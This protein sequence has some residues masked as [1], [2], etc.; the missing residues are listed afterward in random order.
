MEVH[1][2]KH[3]VNG[4]R[5]SSLKSDIFYDCRIF[6]EVVAIQHVLAEQPQRS[7]ARRRVSLLPLPRLGVVL[8][9]PLD[10]EGNVAMLLYGQDIRDPWLGFLQAPGLL[11][12]GVPA[13]PPHALD[14]RP[15]GQQVLGRFRRRRARSTARGAK[16]IDDLVDWYCA[17]DDLILPG[18]TTAPR[19]R[20]SRRRR[21][22][23]GGATPKPTTSWPTR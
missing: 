2:I 9:A 7:N 14:D 10:F 17:K 3:G 12:R 1:A 5:Q 8:P 4:Y 13:G 6:R 16:C 23:V 11:G 22:S 18:A 19:G 20:L 15:L 21:T